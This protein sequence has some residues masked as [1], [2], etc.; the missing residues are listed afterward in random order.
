LKPENILITFDENPKVADF[1]LS[2]LL[3]ESI[4]ISI[5]GTA[6]YTAPE[7]L[8]GEAVTKKSDIY[9]F[10]ILMFEL[11]SESKVYEEIK[12]GFLIF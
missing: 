7:I 12:F 4:D 10:G 9:S 3:D 5:I 8:N 2:K 11:Y 6:Q 1:G